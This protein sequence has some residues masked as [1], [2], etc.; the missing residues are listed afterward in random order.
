MP[1]NTQPGVPHKG[2]GLAAVADLQLDEGRAFGEYDECEFCGKK[3][4]RYVPLWSAAPLAAPAFPIEAKPG[5]LRCRDGRCPRS[6][7]AD[8]VYRLPRKRLRNYIVGP[9]NPPHVK[10]Q[11]EVWPSVLRRFGLWQIDLEARP[12]RFVKC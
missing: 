1:V 11:N 8:Q 10:F 2:W 9:D 12:P 6:K 4:I 3:Q 7:G 5:A